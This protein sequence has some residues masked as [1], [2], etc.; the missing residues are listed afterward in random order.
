M[1]S[2]Y[3]R[4]QYGNKVRVINDSLE[5]YGLVGTVTL[6]NNNMPTAFVRFEDWHGQGSKELCFKVS[7]LAIILNKSE[8]GISGMAVKGNYNIAWV[9]FVQGTNTTKEYAFAL[10]DTDINKG[11]MVL[12]DTANG[13]GVAEVVRIV[14][15]NE[16]TGTPITKEIVCRVDFTA[17]EK[18]K[19]LRKQKEALKKQM[20]KMVADNQELILYQAIAE[21]NPE[22]AEMLAAYRALSNI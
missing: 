1:S 19:E 22:M 18:R 17:F 20:D 14:P 4:L 9:K 8:D 15:Q 6:V 13:Y 21:K 2:R 10:F 5:S 7:N 16:H 3:D 12:C 11:D